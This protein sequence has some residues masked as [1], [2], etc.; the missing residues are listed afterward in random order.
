[1]PAPRPHRIVGA[2]LLVLALGL[3]G[4]GAADSGR[5]PTPSGTSRTPSAT[6]SDTP[7]PTPSPLPPGRTLRSLGYLNG[8]VEQFSVPEAAVVSAAVDQENN[9]TVVLSQPSA[10]EV[11][12]YLRATLP[13]A[14]FT[15]TKDDP[16]ALAMTFTGF[17][18]AGSFTGSATAAAVLLRPL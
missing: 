5:L 12:N 13:A 1:M 14:G 8:P 18:W 11:A 2:I 3:S 15:I 9:V 16:A 10:A 17:G 7:Q 6:P 4:C